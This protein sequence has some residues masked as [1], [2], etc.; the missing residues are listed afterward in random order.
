M[1]W[2]KSLPRSS[3]PWQANPHTHISSTQEFVEQAKHITLAPG[4]C[5]SSYDVSA[6]FTSVPV[7]PALKVFKDLLEKNSTFKVRTVLTVEDII[8]LLE[9]C[10]RNTYFSFQGKFYEQVDDAAMGSPVSP[11]IANLYMEY[12]EQKSPQYCHPPPGS[13]T[14]LWMPPLSSKRKSTNRISCNTSIVLT[15]TLC[16]Q[17]KTIRRMGP[18]PSWTPL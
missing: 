3:N 14:G 18:S 15:L 12:F 1:V 16:L 13:G 17:W 7:Y 11:I 5:L 2:L 4:E 10:L 8:Q 9:F 6:L